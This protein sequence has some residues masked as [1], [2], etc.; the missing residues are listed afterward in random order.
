[1]QDNPVNQAM[2]EPCATNV[3]AAATTIFAEELLKDRAQIVARAIKKQQALKQELE[4]LEAALSKAID[5]AEGDQPDY[6]NL[7]RI[8]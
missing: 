5:P 6:T 8:V 1:M 3:I 2:Q 4:T 7:K